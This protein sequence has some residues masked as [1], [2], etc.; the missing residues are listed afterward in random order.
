MIIFQFSSSIITKFPYYPTWK[1]QLERSG[2]PD[3]GKPKRKIS[4]QKLNEHKIK[5]REL[6]N[7][8]IGESLL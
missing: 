6:N 8:S 1:S 7:F 2:N 3:L 5:G 4:S